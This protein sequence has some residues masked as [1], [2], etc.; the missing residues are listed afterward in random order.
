MSGDEVN[1]F[2]WSVQSEELLMGHYAKRSV[3]IG[4]AEGIPPVA[5]FVINPAPE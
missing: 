5:P 1:G 2:R 3:V 4:R